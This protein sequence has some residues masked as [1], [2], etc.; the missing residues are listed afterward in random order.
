MLGMRLGFVLSRRV[1]AES[2]ALLMCAS[3]VLRKY[4]SKNLNRVRFVSVFVALLLTLLFSYDITAQRDDGAPTHNFSGTWALRQ[5]NGFI[6]TM[7]LKQNGREITGTATANARGGVSRGSVTERAI[8]NDRNADGKAESVRL[9]LAVP[10][11]QMV[12]GKNNEAI[13]GLREAFTSYLKGPTLEIVALTARPSAQAMEE[14]RQS[15]C[16]YVLFNSLVH[17]KGTSKSGGVLGKALND[18]ANST[19]AQIP[20]TKAANTAANAPE[21]IAANAPENTAENTAANTARSAV[22]SA[23]RSAAQSAARTAADA[24]LQELNNIAASIQAKDELKLE[25]KLQAVGGAAPLLEKSEK[26][27]AGS[28]GEDVITPLVEKAGEAIGAAVV[29]K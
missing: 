14:S 27:R 18:I 15:K 29:K 24:G 1:L 7:V 19:A 25:Y 28:D 2:A 13:T 11:V 21:N 8:A 4:M 9:C 10:K 22:L 12:D 3:L 17:K 26:A 6:V 16:D 20:A 5:S 23:T